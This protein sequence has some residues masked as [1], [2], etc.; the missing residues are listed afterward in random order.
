MTTRDDERKALAQI[1]AIVDKLGSDSY[2]ATA[3]EGA[4][5]IAE[6][7]ID[8]DFAGSVKYYIDKADEL[9]QE[10]KVVEACKAKLK[11]T[12]LDLETACDSVLTL[13]ELQG[14]R[15][16]LYTYRIVLLH[17]RAELE[18]MI[19]K[20][21]T[22]SDSAEFKSAVAQH[23]ETVGILEANETM[24]RHLDEIIGKIS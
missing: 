22:Q 23:T 12:G 14:I 4:F 10:H 15:A 13:E 21:A 3:F 7:N 20:Y 9:E 2:V 8:N 5:E 17:K 18:S 1:K 24:Y 16:Q 11:G 19:I 6:D